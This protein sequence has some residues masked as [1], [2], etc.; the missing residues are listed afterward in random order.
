MIEEH[1]NR[2]TC[3]GYAEFLKRIKNNEEPLFMKLQS[4]VV[5]LSKNISAT[6]PRLT[7]IQHVLID[8]LTFLDP[9]YLRFPKERR[10]YVP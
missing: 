5:D 7:E 6:Y 8:I 9:E 4:D 2:L 1:N 3:I 10:E